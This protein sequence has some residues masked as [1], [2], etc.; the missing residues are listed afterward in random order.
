MQ[1]NTNLQESVVIPPHASPWLP[2]PAV[3]VD[4]RMLYRIGDEV[5]TTTSVVRYQP[6]SSFPTHTHD[7]G[8][9]FFVLEGTFSD[10]SG[11]FHAGTYVR[12]PPG[13]SHA[14]WTEPG[15]TILVSLR[16]FRAN[17]DQRVVVDSTTATWSPG[18]IDGLNVLPLHSHN[19]EHIALVRW[20]PGTK[21]KT[22]QHWGGE[23]IFVIDGELAD[24]HGHY[25]KGTWIRNPH[26]STHT[27]WSDT[28]ALIFVKVG[29]LPIKA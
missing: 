27:P 4:R 15:A 2:S 24:E 7:A 6:G 29:H 11:D 9:E 13:S 16:Q 10:A 8:E 18:L 17:D 14:P 25:P 21:F 3:G 12:N 28:G 20:A 19:T 23:E 1:L 5:A 26:G 22:H